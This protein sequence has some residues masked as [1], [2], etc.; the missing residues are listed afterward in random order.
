MDSGSSVV[1]LNG[2]SSKSFQCRRAVRQGNP[3]SPL[4][5]VL[6]DDLLQYIINKVASIANNSGTHYDSHSTRLLSYPIY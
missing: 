6:A 3:M 4:L 1:L 2:V 5:F